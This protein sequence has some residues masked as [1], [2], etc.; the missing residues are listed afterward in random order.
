MATV[1]ESA[2]APTE[3][4]AGLQLGT[5]TI[6]QRQEITFTQY[7]RVVLPLDGFVFWVNSA[8]LRAPFRY[9]L[10]GYN[11]SAYSETDSAGPP[12]TLTALGSLHYSSDVQQ[13]ESDSATVNGVIF[14]AEQEVKDLNAV[15][16]AMMY[17]GEFEGRRFAFSRRA[18]FYRQAD[19]WHYRGDAIYATM[20]PQLIDSL[21]QLGQQQLVVSNSLPIWLSLTSYVPPYKGMPGALPGCP[22]YPSFAVPENLAPPYVAVHI[23]PGSTRPLQS[24]PR[25]DQFLDSYQLAADTVQLTLRGLRNNAAIDFM[26]WLMTYSV[27][28]DNFGLMS[29]PIIR[30]DKETQKEFGI[31]A[32]KKILTLEVSYYQTRLQRLSRQLIEHAFITLIPEQYPT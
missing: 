13:N 1:A 19:L 32:Q 22:I 2:G 6:S 10:L 28:T 24:V 27:D 12:T 18:A 8:L 26:N 16:P 21:D 7:I 20:A 29:M 15:S 5:N 31:L 11:E 4:G 9:N 17:V 3:F 30:D 23:P 25:L 14:T